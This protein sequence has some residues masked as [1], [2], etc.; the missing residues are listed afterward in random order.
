MENKNPDTKS[1]QLMRWITFIVVT[2]LFIMA[3]VKAILSGK[4]LS[5][6]LTVVYIII[7]GFIWGANIW[8]FIKIG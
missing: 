8:K 7:I 2:I 5:R 1:L 6:E 4:E 3:V